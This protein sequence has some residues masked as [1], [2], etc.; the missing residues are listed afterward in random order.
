MIRHFHYDDGKPYYI[1][2]LDKWSE[3]QQPCWRCHIYESEIPESVDIEKWMKENCKTSDIDFRF[4]SG[5]PAYFIKIYDTQE[6]LTFHMT[7]VN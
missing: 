1:V 7:W 4:N 6:F 3:P 2:A 5:A